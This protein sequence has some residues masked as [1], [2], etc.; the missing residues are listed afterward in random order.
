MSVALIHA[1]ARAGGGNGGQIRCSFVEES[2]YF[3]RISLWISKT[4]TGGQSV[5]F[6]A[7]SGN[8]TRAGKHR[9]RL[10]SCLTLQHAH[11]V[12]LSFP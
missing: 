4:G 7:G 12:C 11:N 3:T 9:S 5:Q 1:P 2:V 10:P 6:K 8:I